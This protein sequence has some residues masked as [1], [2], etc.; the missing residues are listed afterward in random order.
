MRAHIGR[1]DRECEVLATAPPDGDPAEFAE[2]GATWWIV[3]CTAR[4]EA[5]A[6]AAAGPPVSR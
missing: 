5:F 3:V 4:A 2:A 1:H 6:R